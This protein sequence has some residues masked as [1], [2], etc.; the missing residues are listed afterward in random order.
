MSELWEKCVC[1]HDVFNMEEMVKF[2][3]YIVNTAGQKYGIE[4]EANP[5][6]RVFDCSDVDF[7]PLM[8][9]LRDETSHFKILARVTTLTL[10][11]ESYPTDGP[12]YAPVIGCIAPDA[13]FSMNDVNTITDIWCWISGHWTSSADW[14][15]ATE[16]GTITS[17]ERQFGETRDGYPL[18]CGDEPEDN[19]HDQ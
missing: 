7:V 1:K 17:F 10:N 6:F 13:D 8:A 15:L 11:G 2:F 19:H 3:E 14:G 5:Y 12:L 4:F 16:Q 18:A 9:P